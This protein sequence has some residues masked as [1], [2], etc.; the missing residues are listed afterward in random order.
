LSPFFDILSNSVKLLGLMSELWFVLRK[1]RC[2][3]VLLI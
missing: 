3:L 1:H 2:T